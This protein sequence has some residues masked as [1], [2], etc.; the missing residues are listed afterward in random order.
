MNGALVLKLLRDVRTGLIVM[1]LLL[2]GFQCLWAKITSRISGD[3]VS[4]V[5]QRIPLPVLEKVLFSGPGKLIRTFMGGENIRIDRAMD[6]LSIGFVHPL[7]QTILCVWAIGRAAGAIAGELDRGTLELLL[8]QP[9]PRYR[10][11]LSQLGVDLITI[12][13]LCTAMWGGVWLGTWLVSPIE[14]A[15]PEPTEVV[16]PTLVPVGPFIIPLEVLQKPNGGQEAEASDRLNMEPSA[17]GPALVEV[18]ALL[19]A[20][21]G[22]TLWL[23]ARGR[24]RGRV[25]GLAVL[26]TL[27]QFLVN[28]VGQLWDA[29]SW[30][31][32][33]TVFYF[34]QPQQIILQQHWLIDL[35]D[36]WYGGR[37]LFAVNGA[38]V[39]LLVGLSGYLAALAVFCRR[40]LPAPL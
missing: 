23:S 36:V 28:V 24:F 7:V 34:Y 16:S 40:D 17:F 10:F 1:A 30:L 26:V 22:Y 3:L 27:L 13:I 32:P 20:V 21:S 14:V 5:R 4:F 29:V 9:V 35:G 25:L 12:P 11:I 31:R 15:P 8:A 19:F 18:A 38:V 39:L 2:G 33:F 6:I 37:A